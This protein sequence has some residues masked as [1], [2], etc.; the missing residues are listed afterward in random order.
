[1][2]CRQHVK[3]VFDLVLTAV[4]FKSMQ[5]LIGPSFKTSIAS[6]LLTK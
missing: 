1:M 4:S 6:V 2:A 5:T 3:R